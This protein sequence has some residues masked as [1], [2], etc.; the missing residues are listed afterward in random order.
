MRGRK[1]PDDTQ[2]KVIASLLAGSSVTEV[3]KELELSHQTVSD[4]RKSIPEDVFGEIRRKK[5]ERLD[6]LVYQCLIRNLETMDKQ[7][8]IVSE[9]EYVIKQPAGE[10]ATLYGVM[11]DKTIRL[12][13]ATT[14]TTFAE[15][16]QLEPSP[17]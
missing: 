17:V 2:A 6:D 15:P 1:L 3:A 4:Y 16:R 13:A 14:N 11:A 9:R 12:L 10:L 7:S 5:G 8:E